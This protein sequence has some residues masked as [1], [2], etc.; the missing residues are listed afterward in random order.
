MNKWYVIGKVSGVLSVVKTVALL[1]AGFLGGAIFMDSCVH[2]ERWK[3]YKKKQAAHEKTSDMKTE[4]PAEE[5]TK[6]HEP[7]YYEDIRN[8][9]EE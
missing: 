4:E 9:S 3:N 7:E 1:G 5:L 6:D 2:P 8:A